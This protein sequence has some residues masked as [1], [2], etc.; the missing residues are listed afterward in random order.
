MQS[1]AHTHGERDTEWGE[2]VE[3]HKRAWTRPSEPQT[4]NHIYL[5]NPYTMPTPH[6]EHAGC[7]LAV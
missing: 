2:D 7:P 4:N 5:F 1:D 6:I 3:I